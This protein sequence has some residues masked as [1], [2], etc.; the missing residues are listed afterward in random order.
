VLVAVGAA[1]RL[2]QLLAERGALSVEE[3]ASRL[4]AVERVPPP[5][6]GPVLEGLLAEDARFV[7][8]D[9][10]VRLAPSPCAALPLGEARFA[11]LDLETTGLGP[12]AAIT[13]AA[14]VLVE[15]GELGAELA[16][17]VAPAASGTV[18]ARVAA[19]AGD[20]VL[21]GH[22]LRFDVGFLDRELQIRGVRVA[23]PALDT[24]ALARR[25]LAGRTRALSLAALVEFFGCSTQP[26]HRALPDARATAEV[27]LH[28]LALAE[29]RGA[30]TVGDVLALARPAATP[31]RRPPTEEGTGRRSRTF[32]A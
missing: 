19:F 2:A 5:L 24:L 31:R 13:E 12:G 23:S 17:D 28:L 11:V 9:G 27:L 10:E 25:L 4:L 18:A 6:A 8:G 3:A 1:D 20:R 7:G 30:A 15:G 32:R 22:N 14:V 26:E 21:C 29:E 16:F